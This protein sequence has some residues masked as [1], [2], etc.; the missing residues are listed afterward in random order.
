MV[1]RDGD[2]FC[3]S[4]TTGLGCVL[5]CVFCVLHIH[6]ILS[7]SFFRFFYYVGSVMDMGWREE[8]WVVLHV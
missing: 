8:W 6:T 2:V 1:E 5:Y 3:T 4:S 7:G